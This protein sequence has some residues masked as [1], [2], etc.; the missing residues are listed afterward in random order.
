MFSEKLQAVKTFE[1]LKTDIGPLQLPYFVIRM[2]VAVALTSS[3]QRNNFKTC[4]R[5]EKWI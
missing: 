2:R 3:S 1:E 4:Q 5:K